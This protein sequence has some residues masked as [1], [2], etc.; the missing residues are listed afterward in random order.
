MNMAEKGEQGWNLVWQH[1]SGENPFDKYEQV[2]TFATNSKFQFDVVNYCNHS[3]AMKYM[4]IALSTADIAE[5]IK[6]IRN[7]IG[8][9]DS[10][11]HPNIVKVF[12]V[13]EFQ[14][15][16]YIVREL[17]QGNVVFAGDFTSFSEE[18]VARIIRQILA[19]IRYMHDQD[20]IHGNL[21]CEHIIFEDESDDSYVKLVEF[22]MAKYENE[23]MGE[24]SGDNNAQSIDDNPS[25]APEL[26]TGSYSDRSDL[27][28]IG[29][30]AYRLLSGKFPFETNSDQHLEVNF[31]DVIWSNKSEDS[32]DFIRNLLQVDV[33]KRYTAK[34]AQRHRW[35]RTQMKIPKTLVREAIKHWRTQHM[36]T[37]RLK[38]AALR[39]MAY[40]YTAPIVKDIRLI[41]EFFDKDHNG[42]INFKEFDRKIGQAINMSTEKSKAVFDKI[43]VIGN[44]TITYCEFLGA[45]LEFRGKLDEEEIGEAFK[46][47]DKAHNTNGYI[48]VRDLMFNCK[49]PQSVAEEMIQ[50]ID[51]DGNGIVSFDEF[52]D[53]FEKIFEDDEDPGKYDKKKKKRKKAA[54]KAKKKKKG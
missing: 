6:N 15:S 46:K 32:K 37:P 26:A 17:C 28:S 11:D 34:D 25:A 7:E 2:G 20:L 1:P 19:A 5:S 50:E 21:R 13:Y 45:T 38:R 41:F 3:Y 10:M 42:A 54:E 47:I 18:K 53:M 8:K 22:G 33:E 48:T 43:D 44:G 36:K 12:D 14:R 23:I 52:L 39:V 31:D 27:W 40:I 24:K 49:I 4:K 51:I 30:M 35:M 29:V 9:M 16:I